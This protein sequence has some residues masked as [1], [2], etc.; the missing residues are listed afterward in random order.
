MNAVQEIVAL[1]RRYG[2]GHDWVIAG[3]GNTSIKDGSTM[4]VKASG[5]MLSTITDAQFVPMDRDKLAAIWDQEYPTE[6]DA[7]E[8]R[9]LEDLMAAR[10]DT[11]VELR[12]SVE[13]LMHALFPQRLV[14]H[15]HPTILNGLTCAVDGEAAAKRLFGEDALWIPTIDPGYTLAKDMLRRVEA[16][17]ATHDG[18][19]PQIVIMQNHGLVVAAETE[20]EI[21]AIHNR[22]RETVTA[23]IKRKPE[24]QPEEQ[25]TDRLREIAE[26]VA[27]AMAELHAVNGSALER[28]VTTA[29][30]S[31]ELRRRAASREAMA[32]VASAFSPDHI[33]YSGHRPCYVDVAE[34]INSPKALH[35]EILHAIHDYHDSEGALPKILVIRGRAAIAVTPTERKTE[36]AH[37]LFRNALEIAAYAES[38]GG[39]LFMPEDQIEFVRNWEVEKFREKQSTG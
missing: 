36:V 14:V 35:A 22:I 39:S 30:T 12:P 13:T 24:T 28:P 25:D 3:G 6:Q 18:A 5:T 29:F 33:V 21:D 38:F 27:L 19:T 20:D 17:K 32:P 9:A 16:W 37:L 1:S 8:A 34:S 23:E 15:T 11:S 4:W 2:D 7:R 31:A 26:I 10:A